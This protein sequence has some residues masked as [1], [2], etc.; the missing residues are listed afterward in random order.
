MVEQANLSYK[1]MSLQQQA[2]RKQKVKSAHPPTESFESPSPGEEK[3][4]THDG[5]ESDN[6]PMAKDETEENLE[7]LLFG[8]TVGFHGALKGHGGSI[9]ELALRERLGAEDG[10]EGKFEGVEDIMDSVDDADVRF[11]LYY[12]YSTGF[13]G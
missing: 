5:D 8:D 1:S 13:V 6:D 7:K 10:V 11:R 2:R 4:F 12:I 9:P 3:L